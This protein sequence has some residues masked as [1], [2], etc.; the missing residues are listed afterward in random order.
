MKKFVLIFLVLTT[1]GAQ[2]AP[3]SWW[4][5]D[6]Y[7]FSR[8]IPAVDAMA[9]GPLNPGVQISY[10]QQ[11]WGDGPLTA[12]WVAQGGFAQFD[13]LF[14]TA[15]L[16]TGLEA[17]WQAP[18]GVFG[19]MALR[20]DYSR[21]YTGTNHFVLQKNAYVQKT[22][23][24]RG[25]LRLTPV[26][27]SIGISPTDRFLGLAPALRFAWSLDVPLYAGDEPQTWSYTQLGIAIHWQTGGQR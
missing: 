4:S 11:R 9:R 17:V 15:H 14:A 26:D 6:I 1:F 22:D 20:L 7:Q 23:P 27:F 2:A 18:F 5:V 19:A 25:Y 24:G 3:S 16:G 10:H 13:K 8:A 21:L 12:G